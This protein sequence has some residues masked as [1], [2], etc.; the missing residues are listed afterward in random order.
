MSKPPPAPSSARPSFLGAVAGHV[1]AFESGD[2]LPPLDREY[3]ALADLFLGESPNT[4][5]R[6]PLTDIQP[7][8][9]GLVVGHLP[10]LATA[11]VQQYARQRAIDLGA[12]VALVRFRAGELSVDLLGVRDEPPPPGSS[13]D[14]ALSTAS[15][16]AA[17]WLVRVDEPSEPSLPEFSALTSVTM[18]TGA[19]E[20]AIVSAYR[21]LKHIVPAS[22]EA[23]GTPDLRIAVM[24]ADPIKA[25][26]AVSKLE[27]AAAAFLGRAVTVSACVAK[28]GGSASAPLFRGP[29][30]GSVGELASMLRATVPAPRPSRPAVRHE[31]TDRPTPSGR[32]IADA[33]VSRLG[34]LHAVQPTPAAIKL[35]GH[36]PGLT[37]LTFD[38]PYAPG[39][40]IAV[41]EHGCL[42][43]LSRLEGQGLGALLTVQ[44]WLKSHASLIRIATGERLSGSALESPISLHLFTADARR[45]RTLG[46]A[47]VRLHLLAPVEAGGHS[48]WFS[49]PLN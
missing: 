33:V 9:E 32:A 14:Q 39:V 4:A 18:L 47:P 3:D 21:T 5:D 13:V 20:A 7:P 2:L 34:K 28:I 29:W 41:D 49:S 48:V 43:V 46:D 11:W 26:E 31:A 6:R 37:P 17:A 35:S 10:V 1:P 36:I 30:H 45:V 22:S 19:D 24:G 40:E 44:T 8:I 15:S 12:P 42:H 27:R 38:C 25:A 23:D 16:H